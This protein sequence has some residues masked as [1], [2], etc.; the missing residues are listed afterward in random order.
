[1]LKLFFNNNKHYNKLKFNLSNFLI[2][3][4]QFILI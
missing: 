3:F 4:K 2:S 1:L